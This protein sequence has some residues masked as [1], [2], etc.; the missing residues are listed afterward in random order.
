[1]F[2]ISFEMCKDLLDSNT[3][4]ICFPQGASCLYLFMGS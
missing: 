1:L 2:A 3:W 4:L